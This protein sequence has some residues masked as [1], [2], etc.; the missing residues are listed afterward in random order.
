MLATL[1]SCKDNQQTS[2]N[3]QVNQPEIVVNSEVASL[4]ENLNLQALGELVKNSKN[5]QEIEEK[6]NVSGSIN[7]LDL[8]GDGNVD[9]IKVTEYGDGNSKGFSFTVDLASNDS[10]EIA[11]IEVNKGSS[12]VEMNIQGNEQLYGNNNHYNSS[13]GLTDLL[14]MNY[15]FSPYHRPY[16]SPYHYGYYPGFYHSY[17]AVPMVS[18][19]SRVSSITKTT[20]ITKNSKPSVKSNIKSP[21][22]S[23]VSSA[24][25]NRAKEIAKPTKSQKSFTKTS[26]SA[27][28]PKT[29]GFGNNKSTTTNSSSNRSKSSFGGS[30]SSSRSSSSRSSSSRSSSSR[31][32]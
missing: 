25:K 26:P 27:S 2:S 17:R 32:R 8:N 7:N 4:G 15:L 10:Q 12:N 22:S 28:K 13:F 19:N 31:R 1:F 11:T 21:N 9:Y 3:I 30:S 16:F 24:V 20:T 29:S 6:L 5:A 23:K 14:I 18:Y